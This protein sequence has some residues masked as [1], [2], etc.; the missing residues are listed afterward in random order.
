MFN[1]NITL[2]DVCNEQV[3]FITCKRLT[4]KI[5]QGFTLIELMITVAIIGIIAAFAAPAYQDYITR[6][7]L[8]TA[9]NTLA[10]TRANMEL[11]FQD[12]RSYSTVGAFVSPCA[13]VN[14]ANDTRWNFTCASTATT[15]T[16]TAAGANAATT[17]FVYTINQN[18]QQATTGLKTSWGSANTACWILKK[19]GTCS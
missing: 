9:T 17:G 18:N 3:A 7:Y 14:T 13:N 6:G 8:V 16:I 4:G 2:N 10:S 12:N 1:C 11:F 19:G 5:H 15:Y